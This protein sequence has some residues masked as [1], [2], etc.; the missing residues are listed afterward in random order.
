MIKSPWDNPGTPTPDPA[1]AGVTARGG[2]PLINTGG[3]SGLKDTI[4]S[5]PLLKSVDAKET[6][7]SVSGLPTT[8][9]RW[10]PAGTPPEPPSLQDRN[11][12]TINE[13]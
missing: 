8:P 13:K 10:E 3:S 5:D 4:W 6:N 12:G 9:S 1:G 11:P 7:N 2:D